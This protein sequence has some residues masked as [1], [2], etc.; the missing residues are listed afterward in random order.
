MLVLFQSH[1]LCKL[2]ACLF[3]PVAEEDVKTHAM[4]EES[5]RPSPKSCP[6][7]CLRGVYARKPDPVL[8]QSSGLCSTQVLR[9][10][11]LSPSRMERI[12]T[13][14]N[15]RKDETRT[16]SPRAQHR[17]CAE[18]APH[19]EGRCCEYNASLANS[20]SVHLA[21]TEAVSVLRK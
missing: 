6:W 14:K 5:V 12:T 8:R 13:P 16:C 7:F 11:R 18:R 21:T 20:H 3:G 2:H 9:N 10:S 17:A 1:D 4:P 15:P 19:S